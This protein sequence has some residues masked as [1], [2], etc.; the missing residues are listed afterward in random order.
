MERR[1]QR[2]DVI[3]RSNYKAQSIIEN[4][5]RESQGRKEVKLS[6]NQQMHAVAHQMRSQKGSEMI[7]SRHQQRYDTVY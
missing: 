7:L 2:K 3:S 4:Q 5:R 6:Q 1:H